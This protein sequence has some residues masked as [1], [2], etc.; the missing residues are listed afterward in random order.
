LPGIAETVATGVQLLPVVKLD[1]DWDLNTNPLV[2]APS[3]SAGL[4]AGL[5][6]GGWPGWTRCVG[7]GIAIASGSSGSP[8]H[9]RRNAVVTSARAVSSALFMLAA[10]SGTD[11]NGGAA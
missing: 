9:A 2:F 6:C 10:L 1:D 3:W 11:T 5:Q 7:A 4:K 8:S